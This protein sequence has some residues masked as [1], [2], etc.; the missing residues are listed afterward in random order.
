MLKMNGSQK[1]PMNY[2]IAMTLGVGDIT[3]DGTEAEFKR[4][5]ESYSF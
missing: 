5:S 1:M 2:N 3:Q 4:A